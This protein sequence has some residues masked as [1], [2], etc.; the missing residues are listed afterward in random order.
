M[1]IRTKPEDQ[2]S[3]PYTLHQAHGR[4]NTLVLH[5]SVVCELQFLRTV[6]FMEGQQYLPIPLPPVMGAKV[7]SATYGITLSIIDLHAHQDTVFV[8]FLV[9]DIFSVVNVIK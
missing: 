7:D 3:T 2:K 4:A 5:K 1:S 8:P 6:A 9:E